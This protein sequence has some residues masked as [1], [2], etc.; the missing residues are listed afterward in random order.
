[1]LILLE[2]SE[3]LKPPEGF[4]VILLT[5][6]TI[7]SIPSFVT[8]DKIITNK[9]INQRSC[10]IIIEKNSLKPFHSTPRGVG[11]RISLGVDFSTKILPRWS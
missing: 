8:H 10:E 9:N 11:K 5:V 6:L 2:P 1:M 3:G 4:L 7:I